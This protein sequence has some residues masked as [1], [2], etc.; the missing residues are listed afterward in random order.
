MKISSIGIS[1]YRQVQ[2]VNSL[3]RTNR[4]QAAGDN[5]SSKLTISPHQENKLSAVSIKPTTVLTENVLNNSEKAALDQV[6][7]I[8][9]ENSV[10]KLGYTKNDKDIESPEVVGK[11]VDVKV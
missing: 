9:S 6:L 2:N 10:S 8:I 7:K 5:V 3:D 1:A 11:I 4:P